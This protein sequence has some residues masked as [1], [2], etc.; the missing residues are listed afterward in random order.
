[1][2]FTAYFY[3]ACLCLYF[4]ATCTEETIRTT[5]ACGQLL[6]GGWASAYTDIARGRRRKRAKPRFIAW[7]DR[8]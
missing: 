7:W 3:V 8:G 2:T 6:S 4:V 5:R 1:V